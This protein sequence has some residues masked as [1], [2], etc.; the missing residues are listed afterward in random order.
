MKQLILEP[1]CE[2]CPFF[3]P[4]TLPMIYHDNL[5][6]TDHEIVCRYQ[7]MCGYAVKNSGKENQ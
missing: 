5:M 7:N 6:L 1:Y 4:E 2:K 3:E